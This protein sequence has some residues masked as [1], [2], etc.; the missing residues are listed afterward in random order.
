VHNTIE[1]IKSVNIR[2]IG[3]RKGLLMSSSTVKAFQAFLKDSIGDEVL[4]INTNVGMEIYYCS[5]T[6]Y[7][8]FIKESALLYTVK[9]IDHTKLKFRNSDNPEDVRKNFIEAIL[10]FAQY[11]QLFLAYTKKFMRL[12]DHNIQS[13]FVMPMLNG[14]FEDTIRLLSEKGK[15]PHFEKIKR[16]KNK[17]QK[18]D[19]TQKIMGTLI[20]EILSKNRR[21]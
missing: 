16:A 2:S 4:I 19:A 6:D 13:K 20:S 9:H 3:I 18:L 17:S 15:V 14:Y 10:T 8:N 7:S 12:R 21:N 5:D 1:N 11:P